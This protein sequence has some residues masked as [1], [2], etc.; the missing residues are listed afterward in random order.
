[1]TLAIGIG[2]NTAV[3]TAY[4]GLALR[5]LQAR[6]PERLMQISRSNRDHAFS[7]PDYTWYRDHNRSF[8]GLAAMTFE[9]FS[10]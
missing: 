1:M 4:N 5:P 3:F 2:V 7:Y 6:E 10:T 9:A 8:S